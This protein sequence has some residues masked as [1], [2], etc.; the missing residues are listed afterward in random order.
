VSAG[1]AFV[2]AVVAEV[3]SVVSADGYQVPPE[4]KVLTRGMFS[5]PESTYMPSILVDMDEGRPTESKHSIGDLVDRASRRGVAVPILTAARCNLQAY[6]ISGTRH[7]TPSVF[8]MRASTAA[9]SRAY[10]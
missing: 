6:E 4:L 2:S 1:A 9:D 7:S 3:A 5:Q 10:A 8:M